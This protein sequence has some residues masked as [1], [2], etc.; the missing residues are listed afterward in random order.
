MT[1]FFILDGN[2]SSQFLRHWRNFCFTSATCTASHFLGNDTTHVSLKLPCNKRNQTKSTYFPSPFL[3]SLSYLPITFY[4]RGGFLYFGFISCLFS[5][6]LSNLREKSQIPNILGGFQFP[7]DS[8]RR[9]FEAFGM[10][11]VSLLLFYISHNPCGFSYVSFYTPT[12]NVSTGARNKK[13]MV[14]RW[15]Q[16]WQEVLGGAH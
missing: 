2:F 12:S 1:F 11:G 8:I 10:G 3:F 7:R 13:G 6:F 9:R 15:M 14:I 16:Y 5:S 4:P